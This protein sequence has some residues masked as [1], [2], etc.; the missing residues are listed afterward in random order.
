MHHSA[1]IDLYDLYVSDP[2]G[3]LYPW[4]TVIHESLA[5]TIAE[6]RVRLRDAFHVM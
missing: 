1:E 2:A 3:V 5:H 4:H 6:I